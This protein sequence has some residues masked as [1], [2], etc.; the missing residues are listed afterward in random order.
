MK[1]IKGAYDLPPIYID[2]GLPLHLN[3]GAIVEE[4]GKQYIIRDNKLEE[5]RFY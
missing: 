3:E 1:F 2:G 4:N 5:V